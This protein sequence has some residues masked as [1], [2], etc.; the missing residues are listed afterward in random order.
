MKPKTAPPAGKGKK[1]ALHS[2]N[3]H[4]P[5][6]P[7]EIEFARILDF[8]GVGW[9][10]EPKTFPLEW[11]E[12]GKVKLA[13]APDFYIPDFDLYVEL[14]TMRQSLVTTK[15]RKLRR[16]AELYPE[17]NV[18]IL[19]HRDLENLM[20]KYGL[21]KPTMPWKTTSNES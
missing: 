19:Y 1:T 9:E 14:T 21:H 12:N 17:V 8:Y 18:K 4:K 16:M 2:A 5:K 15:N 3:G 13:F 11:D 7:A 20:V 10:Y 6:H